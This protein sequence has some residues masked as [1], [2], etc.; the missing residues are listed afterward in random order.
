[1]S[2][3]TKIGNSINYH[4]SRFLNPV[5]RPRMINYKRNFQDQKVEHLRIGN[6]TFI[7][8]KENLFLDSFVYIGHHNFIEASNQI[9]IGKG[10]QIT[11]FITITSH[12]SHHSIRLYGSGYVNH[13][14]HIGYIKGSVEIGEFTFVGPHTTLMP[15]TKIGKGCI[16]SAYS[17]LNDVYPDYSIIAGNP[18]KVVGDVRT[19]DEKYLKENKELKNLYMN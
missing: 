10:V 7:D 2:L 16:V 17:Y 6:S 19:I 11:S 4:L 18:A 15:G 13:S 1:M 5:F 9:R 14:N 3:F 8:S 12:S